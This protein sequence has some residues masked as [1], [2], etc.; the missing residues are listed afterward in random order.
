MISLTMVVYT[1]W[2]KKIIF[3]I[4]AVPPARRQ[5]ISEVVGNCVECF[6]KLSNT[7]YIK[8]DLFRQFASLF[9]QR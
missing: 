7:L 2:H 9:K 8:T 5:H 6:N 1:P 3:A 4:I